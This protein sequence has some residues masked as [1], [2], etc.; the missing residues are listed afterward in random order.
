M[1][2]AEVA[3]AAVA[4]AAQVEA[5]H[6]VAHTGQLARQRH[7]LAMC[8]GPVL[9]PT[10]HHDDHAACGCGCAQVQTRRQCVAATR[11]QQREFARG[12]QFCGAGTHRKRRHR[13]GAPAANAQSRCCNQFRRQLAFM[14]MPKRGAHHGVR[15]HGGTRRLQAFDRFLRCRCQRGSGVS[16]HFEP[17]GFNPRGPARRIE[18][19]SIQLRSQ[20][21]ANFVARHFDGLP[22]RAH[23]AQL[24][25]G[26]DAVGQIHLGRK[27]DA[28]E[29]RVEGLARQHRL[30]QQ[31]VAHTRA[32][33]CQLCR[34]DGTQAQRQQGAAAV[35]PGVEPGRAAAQVVTPLGPGGVDKFACAVARATGVEHQRA[36]TQLSQCAR[37][38]GHHGAAAVHLFGECRHHQHIAKWGHADV[39]LEVQRTEPAARAFQHKGPWRHCRL[40]LRGRCRIKRRRAARSSSHLHGHGAHVAPCCPR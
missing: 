10:G 29:L 9:R 36:H 27:A 6:G 18:G 30:P 26:L 14:H 8:A 4:H 40:A 28:Q 17:V 39:R 5:Q 13:A 15:L 21:R 7:K 20:G 22:C 25:R 32:V 16:L 35:A 19:D 11:Q 34:H 3:A 33:A 37:L 12:P 1:L 23:L 24:T 2:E 31:Q 38:H